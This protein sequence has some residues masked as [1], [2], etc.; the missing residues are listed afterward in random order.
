MTA[1]KSARK[2]ASRETQPAVGEVDPMERYKIRDK[3]NVPKRVFLHDPATKE[4][5]EDWL[6][7]YSSLSDSFREAR[8][9][10]MQNAAEVAATPHEA[11]R[12]QLMADNMN[13]MYAG[14]IA[15]WSFPKPC[16]PENKAAFLADAPQIQNM[17]VSVADNSEAFFG[18][19]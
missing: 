11:T 15:A 12:K 5:T 3:A 16:T 17:L 9:T 6:E 1:T 13:R 19:V 7:V 10:A 8:D 2:Q 4:R 18:N 14:L